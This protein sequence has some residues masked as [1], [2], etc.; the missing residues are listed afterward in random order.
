MLNEIV[1]YKYYEEGY[2]GSI[3]E[4]SFIE[5]SKKA[6]SY[7]NNFTSN[8]ITTDILD[9]NIRNCCC[10]IIDLLFSQ[11]ELKEKLLSKDAEIASETVGSH[12]ITLVNKNNIIEKQVLSDNELSKK[13]YNICYRYLANTGLLYRGK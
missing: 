1:D 6:S 7:L 12:S 2:K 4:S 11:S 5:H 10:E 13:I 8:R 3:P 9:D